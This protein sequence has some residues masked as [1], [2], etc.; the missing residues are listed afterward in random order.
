MIMISKNLVLK[1]LSI[2]IIGIFSLTSLQAQT[3]RKSYEIV[4]AGFQIGDMKIEEIKKGEIT[5][6][7]LESLVSFWFFGKINVE[8]TINSIYKDGMM[9][10]SD[11]KSVSNRGSFYSKIKWNGSA[12]IVDS[13]T[14]KFDNTKSVGKLVPFSTV[15]FYFKEPK[16]GQ[17]T[18]SET[19]GLTSP[20]T[21]KEDGT[22]QIEIDGNKNK[23]IYKNGELDHA[24]MQNPI[25]NYVIRRVY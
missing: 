16:S 25:K 22:Y 7:N 18:I 21:L 9:I 10:S 23:F 11:S 19:F 24:L 6:Y 4:L 15:R 20:I 8:V 13:H 5:E 3:T 12:Y 2:L 14:Y 17:T 1:T